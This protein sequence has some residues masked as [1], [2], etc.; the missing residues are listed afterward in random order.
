MKGMITMADN[1]EKNS[2]DLDAI[3]SEINSNIKKEVSKTV[4]PAEMPKQKDSAPKVEEAVKESQTNLKK[5]KEPRRKT[6]TNK[7]DTQKNVNET[8]STQDKLNPTINSTFVE[9][10]KI[11]EHTPEK[12]Y[13]EPTHP[14]RFIAVTSSE[15]VED[16]IRKPNTPVS[17]DV[18]TLKAQEKNETAKPS[19]HEISREN[20][21]H[22]KKMRQKKQK[23]K[24]TKRQ[25]TT[26]FLG[27]IM[28]LF[29][30]IGVISTI[31]AIV[32]VSDQIINNTSQKNELAQEI[33]PFVI[34]DI[35]EFDNP[36]KLDNSAIISSAIWEFIINEED[37]SKYSKDNLGSLY[38]PDVDIEHYIRKLYGNDIK[39]QHQSVDDSSVIMNYDPDRKMY[40]VESTPKFLPYKPRVDKISKSND[41]YT[42]KVSYILPDAMWNFDQSNR[43]EQVDKTMEYVLK[44]NKNSY[45]VLSVKLLSVEG[46]TSS[47]PS[48]NNINMEGMTED[49]TDLVDS[50]IPDIASSEE[51]TKES[52][53]NKEAAS[54]A[55]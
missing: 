7:K 15:V 31:W 21:I 50:S 37:K 34:I 4:N 51:T 44:K 28:S 10:A 9:T 18:I 29:V 16:T 41:I 48:E 14:V 38:V 23:P 12:E 1:K 27:A 47:Q 42:L 25:K 11:V 33:F 32:N 19:H 36:T 39:I 55:E 2:V 53:D 43:N 24:M 6:T 8:A 54:K 13:F 5:K 3:L 30:V 26:A 20:N 52:T 35:P 22:I 49:E 40:N 45:Q 46:V 17:D